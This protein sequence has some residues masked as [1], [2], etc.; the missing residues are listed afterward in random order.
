MTAGGIK[1]VG[2]RLAKESKLA[3][4]ALVA[5]FYKGAFAAGGPEVVTHA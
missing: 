3:G 1:I 4:D 5:T 2:R